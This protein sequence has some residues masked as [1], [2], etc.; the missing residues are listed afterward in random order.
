MV[1]CPFLQ[2]VGYYDKIELPKFDKDFV[3]TWKTNEPFQA[4]WKGNLRERQ[5]RSYIF[6]KSLKKEDPYGVDDFKKY[7]LCKDSSK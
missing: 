1:P 6:N 3:N 2:D 4:F 7:N 5:A